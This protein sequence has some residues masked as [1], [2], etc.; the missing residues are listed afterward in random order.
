M[1]E[2]FTFFR[3]LTPLPFKVSLSIQTFLPQFNHVAFG[4]RIHQLQAH[5]LGTAG[6][7]NIGPS[8]QA[9]EYL[10]TA[11]FQFGIKTRVPTTGEKIMRQAMKDG[12][13]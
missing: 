4:A 11:A 7:W 6:Y 3:L 1:P 9:P 10:E 12:R 8:Y 5:E 13:A 2:R